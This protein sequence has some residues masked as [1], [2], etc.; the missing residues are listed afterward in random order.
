MTTT[1]FSTPRDLLRYAVTRFN[2]ARLFFGHG[3]AEA[4]D[5][6][7]YLILHTLKLPLDKLDPFLDAR[8]LPDEVLQ[9]L[10]VIER[11]ASE[12]VPAAYITNEAWLGTYAFYVDERVI[13]PRSFIAELIAQQ[14]SPWVE[15]PYAVS[16]ILELCTGSGCLSIMMADVFPNALVDAVDISTDALAVA[17]RNIRHYQLEGRVN[18][19][20]SDLYENVPFKK[21]DMI[22]TNPPYVNSAS[23]ASLPQ[24]YLS[25]PQI[26]LD[27]GADGMD[28]VRKIVAG[29][30]E[31]LTPDGI[32]M[33]EIGNEYDFAEAAFGHLGLTWLTTSAGDEMVFLLTAE[34]LKAA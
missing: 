32:L 7:A 11:R 15:D 21:Y 10:S 16:N 29:A 19:I 18:P 5:E 26:A 23:M 17:E 22:I 4:F 8:L 33:V 9:V 14:F 24:E 13:V 6:A 12:R 34:Q 2:G 1:L 30:A 20:S 25:E 31:R 3:S 27:G 28:L